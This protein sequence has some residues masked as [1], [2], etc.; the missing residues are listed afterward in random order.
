MT[1]AFFAAAALLFTVNCAHIVMTPPQSTMENTQRLRTASMA[2]VQLGTF[3]LDP[4]MPA[5]DDQSQS[6]RGGNSVASPVAGSFTQYLKATLA[7][8]LK[9]VG[10]LDPQSNTVITGSMLEAQLNTNMGTASGQL[11]T[12]FIVTRDQAVRYDREL[13]A[14]DSW[15]GSFVAAIAIPAAANHY[16]GLFRK[17]VATLLDDQDFRD[18]VRK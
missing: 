6:M 14:A 5:A 13:T 11:R 10:L 12:R 18:A 7:E 15:K 1:K 8:E 4:K 3:V 16:Q 2:P 17:M 9:A